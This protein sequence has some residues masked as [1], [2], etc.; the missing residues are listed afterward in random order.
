M[1]KSWLASLAILLA[2]SPL[3]GAGEY[4]PL[5]SQW[6][7]NVDATALSAKRDASVSDY[8]FF[9]NTTTFGPLATTATSDQFTA[10]PRLTLGKSSCTGWGLQ[11]TYWDFNSTNSHGF[12]GLPEL[13]PA[14]GLEILGQTAQTRAYT[15]DV[16]LTKRLRSSNLMLTGTLG[17]RYG[18][19]RNTDSSS[20]LGVSNAFDLY[21]SSAQ[22]ERSFHGTGLTYSLSGI[23]QAVGPWALYTNGRLS[24]LF[25]SNDAS[26]STSILASGPSG[27]A[28][29]ASTGNSSLNDTLLIAETQAGV[30]WSQCLKR[31][32]GRVFARAGFEYQYWRAPDAEASSISDAGLTGSGA[33]VFAE[34][35]SP[36]RTRFIGL[37]V[38]TGYSW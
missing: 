22:T 14:P 24:N 7:F 20:A 5:N 38:G 11:T 28:S 9:D 15:F 10:S 33:D 31:T 3:V 34:A 13:A 16:E 23:R 32:G 1:R 4:A 25:G 2:G 37:S 21:S 17:A 27:F 19:L 12:A 6:Y 29:A 8:A 30:M 35:S 18:M 36:L 26:A